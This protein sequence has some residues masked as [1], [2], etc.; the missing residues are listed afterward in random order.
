M[1]SSTE[2]KTGGSFRQI[3]FGGSF[4]CWMESHRTGQKQ[5]CQ[6]GG[7][8][9]RGNSILFQS[10]KHLEP[11]LII[12]DMKKVFDLHENV[13]VTISNFVSPY[14]SDLDRLGSGVATMGLI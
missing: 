5:M 8:F 9:I 3:L 11:I 2:S 12:L 6:I 7:L 14:R 4:L 10:W 13:S 1:A